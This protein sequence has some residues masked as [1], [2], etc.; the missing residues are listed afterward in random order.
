MSS[1]SQYL[2]DNAMVLSTKL[3]YKGTILA[4]A[5]A[6]LQD[7]VCSQFGNMQLSLSIK[8][9]ISPITINVYV[10]NDE[11]AT[12][13]WVL[14]S[15]YSPDQAVNV[16]SVNL[17]YR[18]VYVTLVNG[19]TNNDVTFITLFGTVQLPLAEQTPT[20]KTIDA[21]ISN[22]DLMALG[23][24]V[25][26]GRGRVA[27]SAVS[28]VTVAADQ[29][30][31]VTKGSK[32]YAFDDTDKL[33][34]LKRSIEDT[35]PPAEYFPATT[36]IT[37]PNGGVKIDAAAS[38]GASATEYVDV[39]VDQSSIIV[40]RGAASFTAGTPGTAITRVMHG[41]VGVGTNGPDF[42]IWYNTGG[43]Y[44][45]VRATINVANDSGATVN[46]VL[47]G[48]TYACVISAGLP[49]YP[50]GTAK[51]IVTAFNNLLTPWYAVQV[52][53]SSIFFIGMTFGVSG[54]TTITSADP[55]FDAEILS[56]RSGALGTWTHI[57]ASSFN[58][59]T[60]TSWASGDYLEYELSMLNGGRSIKLTVVDKVTQ[61]LVDVCTRTFPAP[62]SPIVNLNTYVYA[63]D[64]GSSVLLYD[65]GIYAYK[66]SVPEKPITVSS[67]SI[68][69]A[70]AY[71]GPVRFPVATVFKYDQGFRRHSVLKKIVAVASQPTRLSL[72]ASIRSTIDGTFR[73]SDVQTSLD[74]EVDTNKYDAVF[75][76]NAYGYTEEI[77]V[78][79]DNVSN[80][81]EIDV[82]LPIEVD[83][84]IIISACTGN[85]A[86]S[87]LSLTLIVE[88]YAQ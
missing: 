28:N 75:D 86:N 1:S 63:Y 73:W 51:N 50:I 48:V 17:S 58:L 83:K 71:S 78:F 46:V 25:L 35:P 14:L 8:G 29:S 20:F 36:S 39:N 34:R 60:M 27:G 52:G 18:R 84:P 61:D 9:T 15:S 6:T 37:Y 53:V 41:N 82:N 33:I 4:N 67:F 85:F 69:D 45:I 72:G 40:A 66:G 23:R 56:L 31:R 5:T 12:P 62:V 77:V 87:D 47:N 30:L 32:M 16:Y 26:M 65:A 10:T 13:T 54:T 3:K 7:E 74:V 80:I 42:G 76:P 21:S 44:P 68:N 43:I 81:K 49:D 79:N 55:T 2:V 59:N 38:L 24:N 11:G 88:H 70:F 19:A 57:P 64:T 22:S